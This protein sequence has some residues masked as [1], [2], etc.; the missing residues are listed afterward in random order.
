MS[1]NG[2]HIVVPFA[3]SVVILALWG[4]LGPA[5]VWAEGSAVEKYQRLVERDPIDGAVFQKMCQLAEGEG[6]LGRLAATYEGRFKEDPTDV[7][8]ALVRGHLAMY[9]SH[10]AEARGFYAAAWKSA[11]DNW[12]ANYYHAR[13][14]V[15]GNRIEEGRRL[16][17]EGLSL[18]PTGRRKRMH[19]LLMASAAKEVHDDK[20]VRDAVAA[21]VAHEG[22]DVFARVEAARLYEDADLV[23]DAIA[24]H[25][26][27][28]AASANDPQRRATSLMAVASLSS[29]SE[30]FE[31]AADACRKAL[32]LLSPDNAQRRQVLARRLQIYRDHDRVEELIG[33]YETHLGDHPLDS[34][35]RLEFARLLREEGRYGRS[36]AQYEQLSEHS[37][38]DLAALREGAALAARGDDAGQLTRFGRLLRE[39][40]SRRCADW[41]LAADCF[42]RT[43]DDKAAAACLGS[44]REKFAAHPETLAELAALCAESRFNGEAT[45]IFSD[46]ITHAE[47]GPDVFVAFVRVQVGLRDT[48]GAERTLES[49]LKRFDDDVDALAVAGRVARRDGFSAVALRA[50]DRVVELAGD[51]WDLLAE[52]ARALETLEQDARAGALWWRIAR[53]AQGEELRAEAEKEIVSAAQ[54]ADSLEDLQREVQRIVDGD[55]KDLAAA[56]ILGRAMLHNKEAKAAAEL[57]ARL[58]EEHPATIRVGKLLED[59]HAEAGNYAEAIAT[60]LALVKIDAPR[61][62]SHYQRAIGHALVQQDRPGAMSLIERLITSSPESAQAHSVAG[63]AFERLGDGERALDE[64]RKAAHLGKD[65]RYLERFAETLEKQD[66]LVEAAAVYER[67]FREADDPAAALPS[68]RKLVEVSILTDRTERVEALFRRRLRAER[69]S[70]RAYE[71]LV[72]LF[73]RLGRTAELVAVI[74]EACRYAGDAREVVRLLS[75]HAENMTAS[76]AALSFAEDL[77]RSRALVSPGDQLSLGSFLLAA[78]KRAQARELVEDAI[79]ERSMEERFELLFVSGMLFAAAGDFGGAEAFVDRAVRMEGGNLPARATSAM[80]KQRAG[81]HADAAEDFLVVCES[82]LSDAGRERFRTERAHLASSGPPGLIDYAGVVAIPS[83]ATDRELSDFFLTRLVGSAKAAGTIVVMLEA[84]C[85]EGGDD[86]KLVAV[87]HRA[88]TA[89][90][91]SP[92]WRGELARIAGQAGDVKALVQALTRPAQGQRKPTARELDA[93]LDVLIKAN[94]SAKIEELLGTYKGQQKAAAYMALSRRYQAAGMP[95][96]AADAITDAVRFGAPSTSAESLRAAAFVM[97]LEAGRRDEAVAVVHEAIN[98]WSESTGALNTLLATWRSFFRITAPKLTEQER[99]EIAVKARTLLASASD[100]HARLAVAAFLEFAGERAEAIDI[101]V[102]AARSRPTEIYLQKTV[103]QILADNHAMG[104]IGPIIDAYFES[105]GNDVRRKNFC[106]SLVGQLSGVHLPAETIERVERAL[107]FPL[108]GKAAA[109]DVLQMA[110][111]YESLGEHNRAFSLLDEHYDE[112]LDPPGRELSSV[113]KQMLSILAKTGDEERAGKYVGRFLDR[114]HLAESDRPVSYAA[115]GAVMVRF[116]GVTFQRGAN[117]ATRAVREEV[118]QRAKRK[119][120]TVRQRLDLAFLAEKLSMTAEQ[121]GLLSELAVELP[122]DDGLGMVYFDALMDSGRTER[123]VRLGERLL[124][125]GIPRSEELLS[126]IVNLHIAGSD[127]GALRRVYRMLSRSR[128]GAKS[129]KVMSDAL[130]SVGLWKDGVASFK[131]Y[132]RLA[133]GSGA[134]EWDLDRQVAA[135]ERRLGQDEAAVGTIERAVAAFERS[136]DASKGASYLYQ[137]LISCHLAAGSLNALASRYED[138]VLADGEDVAALDVL[139]LIEARRGRQDE[140]LRLRRRLAELDGDN[141]ERTAQLASALREAREFT[142][143]AALYMRMSGNAD[144]QRSVG[145]AI[146]AARCLAD[147][148]RVDEA[149]KLVDG[150]LDKATVETP[151]LVPVAANRA[152]EF[153][154]STGRPERRLACLKLAVESQDYT[155]LTLILECTGAMVEGGD[156]VGAA[157]LVSKALPRFEQRQ[158]QLR[159]LAEPFLAAGAADDGALLA[160]GE[161]LLSAAR[162]AKTS[163]GAKAIV[164]RIARELLDRGRAEEAAGLVEKVIAGAK[165][166]VASLKLLKDIAAAQDRR[167]DARRLWDELILADRTNAEAHLIELAKQHLS[168][169]QAPE[170]ASSFDRAYAANRNARV[171]LNAAREMAK[172]GLP[173]QAKGYYDRLLEESPDHVDGLRELFDLHRVLG[174]DAE[175]ANMIGR[176]KDRSSDPA[177]LRLAAG[178][179]ERLGR[180]NEAIVA[181]QKSLEADPE[182]ADTLDRLATALVAQG[183]PEEAS[184]IL[185]RLEEAIGDDPRKREDVTQRRIALY[186]QSG[187]LEAVVAQERSRLR[188][189][190]KDLADSALRIARSLE[191]RGRLFDAIAY[192]SRALVFA[193]DADADRIRSRIKGLEGRLERGEI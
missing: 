164:R 93:A 170:A 43:G 71:P 133:R 112:L 10:E 127:T 168:W 125:R 153:F 17:S 135:L 107:L 55:P 157:G 166:D 83:A 131:T 150:I 70:V 68:A 162:D 15:K 36:L 99:G 163:M 152:A 169:G 193:N 24:E 105:E 78:G 4:L 158:D 171:L 39:A 143:A 57:F 97:M 139:A 91:S 80:L 61:R 177:A 111:Y 5:G 124:R 51:R 100:A 82:V 137:E 183:R 73:E 101:Y 144:P 165:R 64:A 130:L 191:N 2:E 142:E 59:A 13:A 76:K 41:V 53:E 8:A 72:W 88:A 110:R 108:G 173:E 118:R 54:R 32:G 58:W 129:F 174:Q 6:R 62:V 167:E 49:M 63:G 156:A 141:V 50:C 149:S 116:L 192:Y 65:R 45:S 75:D 28:I 182:S 114:S 9:L 175:A 121:L 122:R 85:K 46:L 136:A 189:D 81:R 187:R 11:P 52:C 94:D 66:A 84:L 148:G 74:E 67:I 161:R 184:D 89:F 190:E 126:E 151:A 106:R 120:L 186:Q 20:G 172:A 176:L 7:T 79:A 60:A 188:E 77:R 109:T 92:R 160:A 48:E 140:V 178:L 132:A 47:A 44:A 104:R 29:A 185:G 90:P 155:N 115:R 34:A 12:H 180:P 23:D 86:K 56:I 19:L 31:E 181:L 26:R 95:S 37:R 14:L 138:R 113:L 21:L 159:D 146:E 147:A 134:G 69:E 123:A 1:E 154:A 22:G 103:M 87:Y 18:L 117:A 16:L 179:Y 3:A 38:N 102:G 96:E 98:E 27:I 35:A 30:R 42:R 40:G 33:E 145:F 119:D 25:E 128:A